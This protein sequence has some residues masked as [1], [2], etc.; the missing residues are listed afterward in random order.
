[1]NAE[2][3]YVAAQILNLEKIFFKHNVC[4]FLHRLVSL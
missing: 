2:Y 3:E 4:K 1:M